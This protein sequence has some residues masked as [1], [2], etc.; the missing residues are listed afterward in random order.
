MAI[1]DLLVAYQGDAASTSAL[2]F[3]IQMASKYGASVTG[4][5]IQ[6]PNPY[7]SEHR[8]WIGN[9]VRELVRRAEQEAIRTIEARFREEMGEAKS[10][11]F[12]WIG[13]TGSPGLLLA[14]MS[15]YFDL[16]LTGQFRTAI[17]S[18]GVG[19]MQP[20]E[21]LRRSGKPLIIVPENYR[22]RPFK[23]DAV[24]AWDGSR[25]AARALTYAMQILET[26]KRIDVVTVQ[27]DSN[28]QRSWVGD[29]DIIKH[30]Q[31]HGVV[32]NPVVLKESGSIGRTILD[33][34]ATADPDVL[35][36]GA[37]GRGKIGAALFG[38]VSQYIL[39]NQ[40]IPV[41]MAH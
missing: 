39:Q 15:R 13:E 32:A 6:P 36:M 29:H 1:K 17:D 10:L 11:S 8:N 21:L 18:G 9:D 31:R 16:L 14:R 40:A 22:V 37:F 24:V 3:A 2:R 33:Y 26:K 25:S 5:H 4:A 41:L 19:A 7:A 30:L 23:E 27:S 20:E 35:V 34:C 38:G 12:E 28:N